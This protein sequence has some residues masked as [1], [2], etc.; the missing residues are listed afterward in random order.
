VPFYNE[1]TTEEVNNRMAD[2]QQLDL[3]RQSVEDWNTWREQH[4]EIRPNLSEADLSEANLSEANLSEANLIKTNLSG[5]TLSG[6]ILY[7]ATLSGAILYGAILYGAILYG[8]ILIRTNLIKT[9]LIKTNLN[10]TDLT[11]ADLSS[12]N[13]SGASLTGTNFSSANLSRVNLSRAYVGWTIFGD[14][15]LRTVK[16][17][18]TVKHHTPSTIGT[19]TLL[20][21]QGDIPE[22]FLRDAGLTDTFIISVRSLA[23]NPIEYYTCFISH[24]SKDQEF[25]KRLHTDLE[26]KNVHCW[27]A[28]KDLKIGDEFRNIIEESI[29]RLDKFLV[30]LSDHSIQS[31]W[32]KTEV[33]AAFEKEQRL[34]K[35]VVF[36]IK[37]DETV[38]QTTMGWAATIRREKQIG[39]FINWRD[40]NAYQVAFN[41]LLHD[42]QRSTIPPICQSQENKKR[43]PNRSKISI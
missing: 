14:V 4:P 27:F 20:R 28:P 16:G 30:I 41:R 35:L 23:Q 29:Q 38:K 9:N 33:E 25:V 17:L 24:S 26:A 40:R 8:A 7:G 36:P 11:R 39:D 15:D 3:L 5:A 13:L 31:N 22:T 21:S 42:L 1:S 6:A 32:V 37:L 19:D 34:N 18:K 12:A 43:I 2:Q 10:M